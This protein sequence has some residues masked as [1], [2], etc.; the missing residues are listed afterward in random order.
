MKKASDWRAGAKFPFWCWYL[1]LSATKDATTGDY[2]FDFPELVTA[3]E[4]KLYWVYSLA[5]LLIVMICMLFVFWRF[6]VGLR[7]DSYVAI[8]VYSLLELAS[9]YGISRTLFLL[10]A[11]FST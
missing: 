10:N 8:S 9:I 11:K 2:D 5:G 1:I 7:A 6:M 3:Y 4:S